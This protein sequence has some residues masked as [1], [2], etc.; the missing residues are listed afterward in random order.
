MSAAVHNIYIEQGA[1]FRMTAVYKDSA[2]AVIDLSNYQGR[3]HV[4]LKATDETP[5][6]TFEVE[7]INDAGWKVIITLP[8]AAS[9]AIQTRGKR[10]DD[11]TLA[12]YDIELYN[13][14]ES[15]V[16]RLLHGAASISPEV[17][18]N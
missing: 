17:T 11:L 12:A 15:D 7:V 14:D 4:R 8:A 9:A 10:H 18:K 16:I 6:A 3:G 5:A 1:T 2:G 13:A